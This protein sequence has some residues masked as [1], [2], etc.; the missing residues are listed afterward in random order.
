MKHVQIQAVTDS[1]RDGYALD[2]RARPSVQASATALL[3]MIVAGGFGLAN[4]ISAH[5][6]DADDRKILAALDTK[7]QKAVE[8]NDAK[9]MSEILADDFVLVEGDGKRL[10]LPRFSGR[11]SVFGL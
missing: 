2:F 8:I 3:V 4:S 1:R 6:S 9:T 5:A 10:D 11:L 7:Y